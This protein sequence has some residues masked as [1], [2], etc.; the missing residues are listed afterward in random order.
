MKHQNAQIIQV[1]GGSGS[2]K[3]WVL[4]Q[5]YRDL[6]S[7]RPRTVIKSHSTVLARCYH[8]T[9]ILG[10]YTR[11]P[12]G[13][14]CDTYNN[15]QQLIELTRDLVREHYTVIY[16]SM[17]FSL[18]TTP[19]RAWFDE[20]IT[21]HIHTIKIPEA[22]RHQ[23]RQQ[24]ALHSTKAR[25][26]ST[27]GGISTIKELDRG[28]QRMR[29]WGIDV[30]EHTDTQSTVKAIK[31]TLTHNTQQANTITAEQLTHWAH[32]HQI[33]DSVHRQRTRQTQLRSLTK[34]FDIG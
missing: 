31:H 29:S 23:Q 3:S 9:A 33:T 7:L 32:R 6:R 14:G 30:R 1:R 25:G 8:N 16:E 13:A 12:H 10:D 22:Q 27:E 20:G 34:W 11:W 15:N 21:Q 24:R 18:T 5:I 28:T 4:H 19:N 2:G 26:I 17:M